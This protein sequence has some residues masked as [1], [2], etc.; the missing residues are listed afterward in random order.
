M[1]IDR[2]IISEGKSDQMDK[3]LLVIHT[4]KFHKWKRSQMQA[5]K[6]VKK[7]AYSKRWI[8]SLALLEIYQL[9]VK[10]IHFYLQETE[11]IVKCAK[12]DSFRI[13]IK[14]SLNEIIN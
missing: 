9:L 13:L 6:E 12:K 5:P 3:Y 11:Q 4:D 1:P 2:Q 14:V 10:R 7:V 8:S